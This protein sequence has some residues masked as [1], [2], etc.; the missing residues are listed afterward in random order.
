MTQ[1]TI[2]DAGTA[3]TATRN[4]FAVLW[5]SLC[6]NGMVAALAVCIVGAANPAIVAA[7][8]S[9]A[10][11]VNRLRRD[12]EDVQ[13]YLYRST[14]IPKSSG[15]GAHNPESTALL[16]RQILEMQGQMRD[17]TGQIEKLR[18]D[19]RTVG[20]RLDKLVG[21]VDLRLQALESGTVARGRS[22]AYPAATPSEGARQV[23]ADAGD[24]GTTI[25]SSET[26]TGN[27]LPPGTKLLGTVDPNM[28]E[29]T[30]EGQARQTSE[31]TRTSALPRNGVLPEG[32][33]QEQYQYAFKLLQQRDYANAEAALRQFVEEHPSDDLTGNA[34]YWMGETF[35]VRKDFPEAARVFLDAYQRFPNGNKAADNLFKLARSLSEIGENA[36]S[37]TTYRELLKSYPNANERILDNARSD[38]SRLN[39]S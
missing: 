31:S 1:T 5:S 13:S 15:A 4:G 36:S 27:Q 24:S 18:F 34:M 14:N 33:I 28:V 16:Q 39:C 23:P 9:L 6:R 29:S 7:Q 26:V 21:D 3:H 38:M 25:I 2:S 32:T 8:E 22:E 20:D 10:D 19:V 17:L 37:C 30:S 11:Q 35:Y 12:L